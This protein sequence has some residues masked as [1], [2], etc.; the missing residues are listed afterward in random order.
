MERGTGNLFE[1]AMFTNMSE[2]VRPGGILLTQRLL[3]YCNFQRGDI[4]VDLGCGTGTTVEYLWDVQKLY[5][6]GVD[7]SGNLLEQG[8]KRNVNLPLLQSAGENMP[9]WD[10]SVDGVLAECS[11]SV[12]LSPSKILSEINRI[13]ISGGKLG[14]TDLYIKDESCD[15]SAGDSAGI[16]RWS[17]ISQLVVE[18]GFEIMAFEDQSKLLREFVASFIMEHGSTEKLWECIGSQSRKKKVSGIGYYLLFAQK[19]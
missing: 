1:N 15:F 19:K 16:M 8:K 13:L 10:C 3:A 9:F 14:I 4:V 7:I 18:H 6:I 11:L 5:G 2:G 17:E 12:M